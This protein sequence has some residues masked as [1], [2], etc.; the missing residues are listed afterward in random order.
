MDNTAKKS[1]RDLGKQQ[2]ALHSTYRLMIIL[3]LTKN[4]QL[5]PWIHPGSTGWVYSPSQDHIYKKGQGY[6]S[7][8]PLLLR[9]CK[10]SH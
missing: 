8:L 5:G 7:Y 4:T 6:K 3:T 10:A 2:L 9:K 1:P